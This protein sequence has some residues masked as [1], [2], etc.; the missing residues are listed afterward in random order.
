MTYKKEDQMYSPACAWLEDFLSNK[1]PGWQVRV[2]DSSRRSLARLIQDCGLTANLPPE[3]PSWDIHVDVV[4]FCIKGR[5]TELA[6]I[7][8]KNIAITLGHISQ[9]LGYSRVAQPQ[10]SLV[11]SPA[12]ASDAL[13]SLLVTFRRTDILEYQQ[14]PGRLGRAIVVAQWDEAANAIDYGSVITTDVNYLGR[15]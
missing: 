8:C 9:V 4:G 2:F 15:L 5:Q 14:Q 3:W 7:E 13:K 1:H 11:I 10:Y 12:G 6:F